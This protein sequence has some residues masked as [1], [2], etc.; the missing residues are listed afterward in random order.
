MGGLKRLACVLACGA[1]LAIPVDAP[2]SIQLGP[3]LDIPPPGGGICTCGG[4]Q[5]VEYTNV[6]LTNTTTG[7]V[8]RLDPIGRD[9]PAT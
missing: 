5:Q 7:R 3:N 6:T 4:L 8:Y 2:A 1:L 9:F